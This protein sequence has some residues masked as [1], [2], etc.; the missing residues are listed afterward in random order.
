MLLPIKQGLVLEEP[1]SKRDPVETPG[2]RRDKV[3]FALLNK[4]VA[5]HV[6]LTPTYVQYSNLERSLSRLVKVLW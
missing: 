6:G 1:G 3:I 2:S 5:V 4:V